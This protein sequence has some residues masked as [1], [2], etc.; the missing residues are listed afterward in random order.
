MKQKTPKKKANRAQ[1]LM[2]LG[3]MSIGGVCGILMIRYLDMTAN[4]DRPLATEL[5]TFG[6]LILAMYAG[7]LLQIMEE[8]ELTDSTGRRVSFKNAIVVMTSNIGGEL[9][10]DGLGF[11]PVGRSGE[12]E[13]ALRRHFTPEFMGRLDKVVYFK[14]LQPEAMEGIVNKYLCQLQKR[15]AANGVQLVLPEGLARELGAS[16]QKQGGARQLRRLVQ[17]QVEG[18]LASFLLKNG[19]KMVKIKSC[20][21]AG[22][23]HFQG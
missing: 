5:L 11:Q 23:L 16:A 2:T 1:W 8:G 12:T 22:D 3:F 10:G 6:L 20:W 17:D 21:E 14:P 13:A 7:I 15:M 9:K 19:K 4:A 18:P